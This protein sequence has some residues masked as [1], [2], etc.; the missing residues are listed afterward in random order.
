MGLRWRMLHSDMRR[1]ACMLALLV[2]QSWFSPSPLISGVVRQC[3]LALPWRSGL[4]NTI[5]PDL[6]LHC[7]HNYATACL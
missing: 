6:D 2:T 5:F 7:A 1:A 3:M 4:R